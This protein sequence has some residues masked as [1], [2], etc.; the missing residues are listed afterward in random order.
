MN[1]IIFF[2]NYILL[3]RNEFNNLQRIQVLMDMDPFG[4]YTNWVNI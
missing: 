2:K 1:E 4:K 3:D